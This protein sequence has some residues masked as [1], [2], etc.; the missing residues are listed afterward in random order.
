MRTIGSNRIKLQDKILALG[1]IR[2]YPPK[3]FLTTSYNKTHAQ[4]SRIATNVNHKNVKPTERT[5]IVFPFQNISPNLF[6]RLQFSSI[7]Q[8]INLRTYPNSRR[9]IKLP[10][11]T[12]LETDAVRFS[13]RG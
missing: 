12:S 10:S 13:N 11:E 7:P 2:V 8:K 5:S 9:Y 1:S 6:P 3:I 4:F